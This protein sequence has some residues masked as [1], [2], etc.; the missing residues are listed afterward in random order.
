VVS[1]HGYAV[2]RTRLRQDNQLIHKCSIAVERHSFGRNG[3]TNAHGQTS[4]FRRQN[5]AFAHNN[6]IAGAK[7]ESKGR[8][9]EQV[10]F[11]EFYTDVALPAHSILYAVPVNQFAGLLEAFLCGIPRTTMLA[12][13]VGHGG[14]KT[15]RF[16][17]THGAPPRQPHRKSVLNQVSRFA[18][19]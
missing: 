6:S 8:R 2:H 15:S 14:Q 11:Y 1:G 13:G 16:P 3:I 18:L 19:R 7:T 9:Y 12:F 10:R 5:W 4:S 17:A